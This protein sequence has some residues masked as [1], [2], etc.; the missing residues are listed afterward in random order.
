MKKSKI[1]ELTTEE[2]ETL[3]LNS[4]SLADVLKALNLHISSGNYRTLKR[5]IKKENITHE[6]IK[7]G[8]G[9]NK[10]KKFITTRIPLEE[11]LI[12]NSSF[13]TH[14]KKRL[15]KENL[16]EDKCAICGLGNKWN[17]ELLTLQLDHI[18]GISDDNRLENLRVLCPNCHSQTKTYGA[19]NKRKKTK[20]KKPRPTKIIWP[21]KDELFKMLE[22]SNYTQVGKLLGVSD[23]AVR[24]HVK[25]Y[26]DI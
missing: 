10:G 8:K 20:E 6:H 21:S 4:Q 14:L 7:L 23:N 9:S 13:S 25:K 26:K 17:N 22:N 1:Y 12:E 2:F 16:L 19:R 5:R 3:I 18:N 24:Y 11:I 15:L